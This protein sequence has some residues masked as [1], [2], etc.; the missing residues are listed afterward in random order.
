MDPK[1]KDEIKD[2]ISHVD[3]VGL[4]KTWKNIQDV[5]SKRNLVSTL[6]IPCDQIGVHPSNRDGFGVAHRDVHRLL[7]LVA[8]VGYDENQVCAW[9]IEVN[10]LEEPMVT[11]FNED[12]VRAG[13]ASHTSQDVEHVPHV[14]GEKVLTCDGVLDM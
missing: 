5:L 7:N 11:K 2:M 12:L 14:D 13:T 10:H 3:G 9:C 6:V 1:V 8:E 4:Q